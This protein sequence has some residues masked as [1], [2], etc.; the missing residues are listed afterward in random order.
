MDG[1]IVIGTKLDTKELEKNLKESQKLLIGYEKEQEKL[2]EQR[3]NFDIDTSEAQ[4]KLESLYKTIEFLTK[5]R[6]EMVEKNPNTK[7][8]FSYRMQTEEINNYKQQA[9]SVLSE[10]NNKYEEIDR[11]IEQNAI[12]QQLVTKEIE[13]TQKKLSEAKGYKDLNKN[14]KSIGKTIDKNVTKVIKW[15]VAF[16]GLKTGVN[17][18]RS[19]YSVIAQYDKQMATDVEYMRYALAMSL[20]PIIEW[21]I[22]AFYKVITLFGF[23]IKQ[24]TGKNIFDNAGADKFKKDIDGASK[25]AKELKK[26]LAGFDEANVLS[27]NKSGSGGGTPSVNLKDAVDKMTKKDADKMWKA[28]GKGID[29]VRGKLLKYQDELHDTISN[30][31]GFNKAYGIWADFVQGIA[32][33]WQGLVDVVS[34]VWDT[35]SGLFKMIIDVI[36]GDTD[37]LWED[38]KLF[39]SGIIEMLGGGIEIMIGAIQ[40]FVGTIIGILGT[41][42]GWIWEKLLKPIGEAFGKAFGEIREEARQNWENIKESAMNFWNGVKEIPTNLKNL[43]SNSINSIKGFFEGLWNGVK[44]KFNKIS[45]LASNVGNG[46]KNGAKGIINFLIDGINK[47]IDGMNKIKWDVPDWVPV[48]GGQRWGINI[49]KI[50]R[51]A[52]GGI[53]NMPNS[54]V[55]V[56]GAITGESGRE[57]VIP[58]TDPNAMA[59][60]GREIGQWVNLA[61]D[62]KMVVDGRVLA[63][64]TNNQL[65]KESFL[66]NR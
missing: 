64:A 61:I 40:L 42:L 14:L 36:T 63:T 41:I 35:L 2:L 20:K 16:V 37:K 50:P 25:S 49:P 4:K 44:D 58:L 33:F 26:Q 51:L 29:N 31:E 30:R 10:V 43:F 24:I 60:L 15:A 54:G 66:M 22:Q 55:M 59:L 45:N 9:I 23:I 6:D 11:A 62:N 7:G 65:N 34:G 53:V 18:L 32:R 48:I 56:G 39:I 19:A 28:V 46:I 13:E 21:I 52:Q 5:K 3:E 57:G 12:N 47:F 1:M 8:G 27:D 38:F 17:A